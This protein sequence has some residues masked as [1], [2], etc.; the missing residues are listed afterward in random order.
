MAIFNH[1]LLCSISIL[2]Q[3]PLNNPSSMRFYSMRI[4]EQE[5][6]HVLSQPL[7]MKI[8][9]KAVLSEYH[10]QKKK[11]TYASHYF[12]PNELIAEVQFELINNTVRRAGLTIQT[13]HTNLSAWLFT[14]CKNAC[15]DVM[16]RKNTL[17]FREVP[18]IVS[19]NQDEEGSILDMTPS[20]NE[21]AFDIQYYKE[22]S[23]VRSDLKPMILI[24]SQN[25]ITPNRVLS[26]LL[27]HEPQH[28]RFED[29]ATA[30]NYTRSL[31]DIWSTWNESYPEYKQIQEGDTPCKLRSR[32]FLVWLLRGADFESSE[33]FY[34]RDSELF[35]RTRDTL[36]QTVNRAQESLMCILIVRV[37]LNEKIN[38]S[39]FLTVVEKSAPMLI[40]YQGLIEPFVRQMYTHRFDHVVLARLLFST[41]TSLVGRLNDTRKECQKRFQYVLT[42]GLL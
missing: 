13:D 19:Q 1:P 23:D 9:K 27:L 21:S 41:R 33:E 39:L 28:V 4:S 35:R 10:S 37:A 8:L 40:S 25:V 11:E 26:Y 16:R 18:Y 7:T 38:P 12:T 22:L 20:E 14:T 32:K 17:G 36:R 30:A 5:L 29:F 42:N 15:R 24:R 2:L 6:Y 31:E 3:E 34:E